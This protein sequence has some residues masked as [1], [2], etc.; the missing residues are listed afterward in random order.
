MSLE[1]RYQD[2]NVYVTAVTESIDGIVS[3]RLLL[4]QDGDLMIAT[5]RQEAP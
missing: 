1:E 4:R 3:I 5:A 2:R